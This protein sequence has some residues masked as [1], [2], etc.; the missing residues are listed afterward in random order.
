MGFYLDYR[1][2]NKAIGGY[3]IPRDDKTEVILKFDATGEHRRTY[4]TEE[5]A[6]KYL[7]A[8]IKYLID[9]LEKR[10]YHV[11]NEL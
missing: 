1:T 7:G 6:C 10:N 4:P 5:D 8:S 2:G 9:E 11:E 3:I